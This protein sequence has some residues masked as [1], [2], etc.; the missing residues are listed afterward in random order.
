MNKRLPLVRWLSASRAGRRPEADDPADMGTAFGLDLSLADAA[1]STAAPAA[2]VS[3]AGWLR[4][5]FPGRTTP[6]PV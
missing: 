3:R 6:R 4:R 1:P 2:V 5:A